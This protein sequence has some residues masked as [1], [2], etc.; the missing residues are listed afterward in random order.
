MATSLF[1]CRLLIALHQLTIDDNNIPKD[2]KR[3][4]MCMS[5]KEAIRHD[6][7]EILVHRRGASRCVVAQPVPRK[8]SSHLLPQYLSHTR[9]STILQTGRRDTGG[10]A[11]KQRLRRHALITSLKSN[12]Q[13]MCEGRIVN[14][15]W[16]LRWTNGSL[17]RSP[18]F[19]HSDRQSK[20][21]VTMDERFFGSVSLFRTFAMVSFGVNRYW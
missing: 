13:E 5:G 16:R 10:A 11:D 8:P 18:S 17:G 21:A 9:P 19:G 12:L 15:R 4:V 20:V 6:C 14:R 1:A 7:L 3:P 2:H